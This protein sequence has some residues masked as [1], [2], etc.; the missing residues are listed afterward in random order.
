MEEACKW[1]GADSLAFISLEGLH[2]AVHASHDGFCD[3]CFS[4]NYV[5]DIPLAM[6]KRSF[7]EYQKPAAEAVAAE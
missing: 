6:K 5:V 3:A 2:R 7:L 4:G 1:I